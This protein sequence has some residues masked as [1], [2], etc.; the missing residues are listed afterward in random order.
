MDH[1]A[2]A[3]EQV[4]LALSRA[5]LAVT[6]EAKAHWLLIADGWKGL[7]AKLEG[8]APAQSDTGAQRQIYP[9]HN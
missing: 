9:H 6:L 1:K 4:Q 7:L 2:L 3:R 8:R 5:R